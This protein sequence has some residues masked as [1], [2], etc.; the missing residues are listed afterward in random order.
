MDGSDGDQTAQLRVARNQSLFRAVNEQIE[1]TNERFGVALERC[2]FVCECADERCTEQISLRLAA[3]E[4][5]R[6]V[7]THFVVMAGHVQRQFE[8]VVEENDRYV[9]VEK[10]GDAGKEAIK[11]DK[12]H[13]PLHLHV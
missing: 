13:S 9:I 3:Y 2:N 11:L 7:P 1:S 6:L 5:V 10:F 12:R 8:R 4:D